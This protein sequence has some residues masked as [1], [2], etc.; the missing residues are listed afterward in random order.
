[1]SYTK[2]IV[3][4]IMR[5][6]IIKKIIRKYSNTTKIIQFLTA[7][8]L[9]DKGATI[10]SFGFYLF[11]RNNEGSVALSTRSRVLKGRDTIRVEALSRAQTMEKTRGPLFLADK[12]GTII[13]VFI[14]NKCIVSYFESGHITPSF[15]SVFYVVKWVLI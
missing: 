2:L 7:F 9:T 3:L 8:T 6:L 13:P 1:M 11:V 10:F 5:K 14:C 15:K 4:W 12:L